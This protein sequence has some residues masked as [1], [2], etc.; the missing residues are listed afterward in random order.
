[1]TKQIK[2]LYGIILALLLLLMAG[3]GGAWY[4]YTQVVSQLPNQEAESM[5]EAAA[6]VAEVGQ[7]IE[8][9]NE[10]PQVATVTDKDKLEPQ[11]FFQKAENGDKILIFVESKRAILYRPSQHKV[12]DVTNVNTPEQEGQFGNQMSDTE[13]SPQLINGQ[14][15]RIALWNGTS[16]PGAT[17]SL[18]DT[19]KQTLTQYTVVAKE[20]ASQT[21]YTATQVVAESE[22]FRDT[23]RALADALGA[24]YHEEL[25]SGEAWSADTDMVIIIGA[26]STTE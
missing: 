4:W 15:V 16:S 5:D 24:E 21:D 10:V 18:E 13:S 14:G 19:L 2:V 23:A 3:A 26:Q 7:L 8:L 12:I 17:N 25:R 1:M 22:R 20:K 9:P 11:P 6:L